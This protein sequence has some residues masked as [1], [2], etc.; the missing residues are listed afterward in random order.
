[1]TAVGVEHGIAFAFD[2][3]E[4]QPNTVAAHSLI[5]LAGNEPHG[6]EVQDRVV[7]ALFTAY[8]IDGADLT[9]NATLAA[10]ATTVPRLDW[11]EDADPGEEAQ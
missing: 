5:A 1:M 8:F 10:I 6:S 11:S 3:I 9:S 2:R 7:E 4:R